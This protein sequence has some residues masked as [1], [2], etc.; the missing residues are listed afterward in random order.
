MNLDD[1]PALSLAEHADLNQPLPRE[2]SNAVNDGVLHQWLEAELRHERVQDIF[3]IFIRYFELVGIPDL[4]DMNVGL[5]QLE[6]I[7]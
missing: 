1:K 2:R 6:F 4:L 5:H 7:F 3:L